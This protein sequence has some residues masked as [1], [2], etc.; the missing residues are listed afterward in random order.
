MSRP[1]TLAAVLQSGPCTTGRSGESQHLNQKELARRWGLSIRTLERWRVEGRGPRFCKL[2][3]KVSYPLRE[4]EAYETHCLHVSTRE[5]V[6][7]VGE[8]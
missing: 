4:I 7:G 3:H 1:S 8:P 2:G 5:R 6:T